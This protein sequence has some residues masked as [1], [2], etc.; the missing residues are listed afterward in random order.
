MAK[1]DQKTLDNNLYETL[2][3]LI[4]KTSTVIPDDVQKEILKTL[5]KEQKNTSAKYAMEIIKSNIE[6]AKKKIQPLCQDTGT[7]LFFVSHPVGFNQ[8][9]F[10][11]V[12]H[13]AVVKATKLGF[14]RQ[15]SVDPI[16]GKNETMNI[17][18][19]HPS[20]HFHEHKKKTVEIKLMLKGG[21]CENVGAQYALPYTA[22]EAGRDLDGVRKVILDAINKAQG[23][24]CGPG[25]IGVCI[26]GDRGSGYIESKEQL[27]RTLDD[28][29]ENKIL[30]KLE[31]DIVTSANKLGIGP[32]GFGGKTT[33]LGCKIGILNRLPASYY[34]SISYMCWAY[35]RQ[36]INMRTDNKISKWLY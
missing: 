13:K 12:C 34:V 36:G 6:I 7:I 25:V 1:N 29:N 33:L 23:K 14:L 18:P 22:L 32:M 17:G 28:K 26:G 19:G 16:T 5:R 3:K 24:G 9:H 10:T 30:A 35:R 20:I 15:N 31:K 4:E 8:T 2:L 21:G 27:L 11:K